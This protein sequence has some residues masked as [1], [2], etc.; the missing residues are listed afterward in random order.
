[1]FYFFWN[2]GICVYFQF[3]IFYYSTQEPHGNLNCNQLLN[4]F[5][6]RITKKGK[7]LGRQKIPQ[8]RE[9]IKDLVEDGRL[10][11]NEQFLVGESSLMQFE[12]EEL[13]E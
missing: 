10:P 5:W 13:E 7:R 8:D 3:F 12:E 2:R 4:D 1:M 9:E 6:S 11:E